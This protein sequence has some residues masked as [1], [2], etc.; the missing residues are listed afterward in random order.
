LLDGAGELLSLTLCHQADGKPAQF[1]ER[2]INLAAAPAARTEDFA[3][4]PPGSWLLRHIDWTEAEHTIMAEAA[5]GPIA[6]RLEIVARSPCLI[7]ER[8]TWNG[9][10]PITFTR[11]W[12]PA[13]SR[14]LSGRF[15]RVRER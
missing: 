13:G 10:V 4:I 5:S 15:M 7:V 12:H 11:L 8:R 9:K 2:L 14:K 3:R 1:E 6:R